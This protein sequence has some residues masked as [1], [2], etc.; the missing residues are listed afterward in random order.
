MCFKDG[1]I[2]SLNSV[3]VASFCWPPHGDSSFLYMCQFSCHSHFC[4]N[5]YWDCK[6]IH[7]RLTY[8]FDIIANDF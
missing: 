8:G 1:S 5:D 2:L 7:N 4:A 6:T 3:C